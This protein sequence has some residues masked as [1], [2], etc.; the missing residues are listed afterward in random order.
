[1]TDTDDDSFLADFARSDPWV[2]RITPARI[3]AALDGFDLPFALGWNIDRLTHEIQGMAHTGRP[4]P[5]QGETE[6]I[7]ELSDLAARTRRLQ[8]LMIRMGDT[9]Q[10][11]VLWEVM[12]RLEAEGRDG[13]VDQDKDVKPLM[14]DPLE[15]IAN[16]LSRAASQL[17]AQRQK[18]T[19]L[20]EKHAQERRVAFAVYL[21]PIFET[22]FET[23]ARAN[24]WRRSY[25]A[26]HPWPDFYRRIYTELFPTVERLNLS[27]VLQEAQ[28]EIPRVQAIMRWFDE[29]DAI[30]VEK[31][32][33]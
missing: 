3:G 20:R 8:K 19:R 9:S 11:A 12:K 23:P 31:R 32:S 10:L 16:V 27:K 22:A 25:G 6:A 26:H 33:E 13:G 14:I 28:R 18:T 15:T 30:R 17:N 29:Q 5:S 2:Q 7:K 24:N 1:M 4:D 21:T